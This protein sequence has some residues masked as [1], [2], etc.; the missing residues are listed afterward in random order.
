MTIRDMMVRTT[1][2][3]AVSGAA[4]A[5][6]FM[7]FAARA[8]E[9]AAAPDLTLEAAY[10]A[11]PAEKGAARAQ[12]GAAAPDLTLEAADPAKKGDRALAPADTAAMVHRPLPMSDAD[13]AAKAAANRAREEAEK[14][15]AKRPF[16]PL[17]LAPSG[18]AGPRPLLPVVVN[19]FP[20][21]SGLTERGTPPDTTGAIGPDRYIQLVNSRAEI[22]N[23]FA[24]SFIGGGTLNSLAAI[25]IA[26]NVLS[27]DP[28]VIWDTQT[29]R[30][31]YTAL[32]AFPAFDHKLGIGFSKTSSP[33]NVTTDWCHYALGF[34]AQRPD[35][36]KL[37]HSGYFLIIGANIFDSRR[38]FLGS[39]LVAISKP[40]AGTACPAPSTFTVGATR[41]LV[42][43]T[44]HLVFTPVPAIQVDT[45]TIGFAVARNGTTPSNRLWFFNVTR[46]P[47]TGQPVFGPA[48]G[49][50]VGTYAIPP[51]APQ[52][53][54]TQLL[55]TSD[56]RM[57]QAVQA[58]D[59][60]LGTFSFWTQHTIRDPIFGTASAVRWYEINPVPATP[61]VLR[62][63]F[64]GAGDFFAFNGAISPD[65]RVDRERGISQFGNNFVLEYNT[66]GPTVGVPDVI[67]ESS[68]NGG[69]T[70]VREVVQGVGPY[71]DFSCPNVRGDCSAHDC[72]CSWGDYS[73]ATPDPR[74]VTG[75]TV[76]VVWGTNQFSGVPTPPANGVNWRTR[77]FAVKP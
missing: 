66:S 38:V 17:D 59:P 45:A 73:A 51:N 18:R 26:P 33:N 63:S 6:S 1:R 29:N 24:G 12:E 71:R 62:T 16:S 14:S 32:F 74:P 48:R 10:P 43:S 76:G 15:G 19:G 69:P 8:Q 57:T 64:T 4:A 47:T 21:S 30:F 46:D 23:R 39:R 60:R 52:P 40:P 49:V 22:F 65:R 72:V 7:A 5:L 55:D 56:A 36:P 27:T 35:F 70:D 42:D 13:V 28:Q 31:Y 37:G 61:V 67:A 2:C 50:T 53:V 34:P 25:P 77:I 44:G 3:L 20:G 9:G 68:I 11:D 41:A 75:G 54:F 58:I